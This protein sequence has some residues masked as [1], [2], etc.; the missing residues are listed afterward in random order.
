VVNIYNLS[1]LSLN[2]N[3][4]F[5]HRLYFIECSVWLT[6]FTKRTIICHIFSLCAF[7]KMLWIFTPCLCLDK[8]YFIVLQLFIFT[9]PVNIRCT[10]CHNTCSQYVYVSL[11]PFFTSFL[12]RFYIVLYTFHIYVFKILFR[13]NTC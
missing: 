6:W 4:G 11:M 1:G 3:N 5:T 13:S 2:P 10:V 12:V 7:Y 8:S 9:W